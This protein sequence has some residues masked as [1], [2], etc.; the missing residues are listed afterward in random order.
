MHIRPLLPDKAA[1]SSAMLDRP[2]WCH[3]M[4]GPPA[5]S[6]TFV[7]SEIGALRALG[8][9]V[10]PV[11]LDGG[12]PIQPEDAALCAE[13]IKL[14]Q[15]DTLSALTAAAA[16]PAGLGGAVGFAQ[17]QRSLA[18]RFLLRD[19]TK[20]AHI[21]RS[22]GCGHIH[23][24]SAGPATAVAICAARIAGLTVSFTVVSAD[25][26]GPRMRGTDAELAL[27]LGTADVAIA[28]N[29]DMAERFRRVAPRARIRAI[30]RGVAADL[31]RPRPGP[32]N[33][34]LLAL[35]S[36]CNHKG[37]H[38][39]LVA[40]ANL[41]PLLRP[42]VDVVGDGPLAAELVA[43]GRDLG[44]AD[45][46]RFLGARPPSWVASEGPQYHGL[47]AAGMI[48]EDGTRDSA[49]LA[50]VEAMAM[51]LPVAA[52]DLPGVRETMDETCGR[53]IEPGDLSALAEAMVWLADLSPACRATLG[54]AGRARVTA[55]FTLRHQAMRLAA[56]VA[57]AQG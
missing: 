23:A 56:A 32:G 2:T 38:A 44:L 3:V 24:H 50:I 10:L 45:T 39:M 40:L 16:H 36:L 17:R 48:A 33:G 11:M 26:H 1:T 31:F 41:H 15:V 21:A 35:G 34:R 14:T 52:T 20:L 5:L 22:R 51:G 55:Q 30:P 37:Y 57:E 19:A 25:L 43:L 47:I 28:A 42:P 18:S 46:V 6:D 12:G 7:A 9:A 49:P 53:L 27:K 13:A 8:Y 54:A 4:A 29:E